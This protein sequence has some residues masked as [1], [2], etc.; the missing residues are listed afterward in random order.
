[1]VDILKYNQPDELPLNEAEKENEVSTFE[2]IMSGIGSGLIKAVGNTVSLGAE[3]LDLGADTNKAAQVEAYFDKINPFDESAQATTAGKVTEVLS[4]LA[5]PGTAGFKLASAGVK[6]TQLADKAIKAKKAGKYLEK[7]NGLKALELVKQAEKKYNRKKFFAGVAGGT[8]AEMAVF[9][10]DIGTFGTTFDFGPTKLGENDEYEGR[11]NALQSLLNRTKFGVESLFLTGIISGLG[12]T[13]KALAK[14]G[15]NLIYSDNEFFKFIDKYIGAPLRARGPLPGEAFETQRK[16]IGEA[17]AT[18]RRAERVVYNLNKG[19]DKLFGNFR[20]SLNEAEK[21]KREQI[22][23]QVGRVVMSGESKLVKTKDGINRIEFGGS[24]K[25]PIQGFDLKEVG[26]LKNLLKGLS[27]SKNFDQ[28]YQSMYQT[29]LLADDVRNAFYNTDLVQKAAGENYK[30]LV[31]RKIG[32][33][34]ETAYP[35]IETKGLAKWMQFKPTASTINTVRNELIDISKTNKNLIKD[36]GKKGMT[37]E[38]ADVIINDILNAKQINLGRFK[39][40][41]TKEAIETLGQTGTKN[42][43]KTLEVRKARPFEY[44]D[45]LNIDFNA[46]TQLSKATLQ[47]EFIANKNLRQI[48]GDQGDI[49]VRLFNTV[50]TL[51]NYTTKLNLS[52]S[53]VKSI[54]DAEKA[55]GLTR[56]D[57]VLKA[58]ARPDRALPIGFSSA[59]SARAILGPNVNLAGFRSPIM[60]DAGLYSTF[61]EKAASQFNPLKD[62]IFHPRVAEAI[63]GTTKWYTGPGTLL[64]LYRNLVLFPKATS[65]VAKTILSPITHVRNL[66][67]AAAFS[68]AN[69]VLP[70]IPINPSDYS[71]FMKSFKDSFQ[72]LSKKNLLKDPKKAQEVYDEMLRLGVVNSNVRLGD[73]SGLLDDI[74]FTGKGMFSDGAFNRA[75]RPFKNIYKKLEDAYVAED[76]FWKIINFSSEKG[77]LLRAYKGNLPQFKNPYTGAVETLDEHAARIV[78]NTVPNYDYVSSFVKNLRGLPFGNFV[79]F[80][81]E[82]IRTGGNIIRQGIREMVDPNTGLISPNAPT[83]SIGLNRLVNS[84]MTFAGVPYGLYEGMKALHGVTEEE[85]Q[86]LRKVVPYW[87]ENSTLLAMGRDNKGNL[88]YKDFSHS[89][90]YDTLI[91]PVQTVINSVVAGEQNEQKVL[92]SVLSGLVQAAQEISA[93]FVE[94]SIFYEAFN[95]IFARGGRTKAGKVIFDQDEDIGN[96][97]YK[98]LGHVLQTQLPGSIAQFERLLRATPSIT[99]T[100]IIDQYDKYGKD[101]MLN[102][103][104][105]GLFGYRT[106]TADPNKALPYF[107]T[108]YRKT[109]DRAKGPVNSLIY[110]GGRVEPLELTEAIIE[111]NKR[112]YR[113]DRKFYNQLEALKTLNV[114][115][116]EYEKQLARI[117]GRDQRTAL[118]LGKFKPV[119]LTSQ[120]INTLIRNA[121]EKGFENP[122]QSSLSSINKFISDVNFMPLNLESVEQ[123]SQIDDLINDIK[124]RQKVGDQSLLPSIFQKEL[125]SVQ[126]SSEVIQPISTNIGVRQS[127]LALLNPEEQSIR[128]RQ[129][130]R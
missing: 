91:R 32:R 75:I 130:G 6:G 39:D 36:Y 120:D 7:T 65:Q 122:I 1:M 93:P 111:A 81:A 53:F 115:T 49:R 104:I 98:T 54:D 125:E 83:F 35:L 42:L 58:T 9:D 8:A 18:R 90:A 40:F 128:L 89:N 31:E 70:L 63:E 100:G 99:K 64:K 51:T 26:K 121:R 116:V 124:A 24:I 78:R 27:G 106:M 46:P 56:V 41:Q 4:Q 79:S 127:D 97:I 3:L 50:E 61:G 101:F 105:W 80:P 87:S 92:G 22:I 74:G 126:P 29:R 52:K 55:F 43:I 72:A 95:D 82:I 109:I 33:Y 71:I 107:V 88:K 102:D 60:K 77:K 45:T 28:L 57:G 110:S 37:P 15:E 84:F 76:D 86:A 67:S 62:Y 59:E 96:Q 103:E 114:N 118:R 5:I 68:T 30:K 20:F 14:H 34:F 13:G 123:G 21:T 129:Q 94:E 11:E 119:T 48:L 108:A 44:Y 69:G 117:R 10:E 16:A 17:S 19:V 85:M 112:K 23:K 113:L 38:Q 73:L 2:S 66:I 25:D 47:R 12:V